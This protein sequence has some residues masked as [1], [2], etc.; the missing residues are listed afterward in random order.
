MQ[1]NCIDEQ[2]EVGVI[3]DVRALAETLFEVERLRSTLIVGDA[4]YLLSNDIFDRCD[5]VWRRGETVKLGKKPVR[6]RSMLLRS[7]L[8]S[9]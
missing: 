3:F 5:G 2:C 8:G 1:V 4:D 6:V 9:R 7:R